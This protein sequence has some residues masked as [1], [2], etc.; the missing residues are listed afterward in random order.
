[1]GASGVH[2]GIFGDYFGYLNRCSTVGMDRGTP[3]AVAVLA[4]LGIL[5][6]LW[7]LKRL[8]GVEK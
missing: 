4:L 2:A 7:L 3:L 8:N 6:I 5:L 1:M